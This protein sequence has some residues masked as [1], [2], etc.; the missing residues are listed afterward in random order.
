[1]HLLVILNLFFTCFHPPKVFPHPFVFVSHIRACVFIIFYHRGF[2]LS[3][4]GNTYT[5]LFLTC[6]DTCS[7]NSYI[8][9][10]Y[11]MHFPLSYFLLDSYDPY[12]LLFSSSHTF[13]ELPIFVRWG[14]DK[15]KCTSAVAKHFLNDEVC[16]SLGSTEPPLRSHLIPPTSVLCCLCALMCK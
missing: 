16:V 7:I 9:V 11:L 6:C 8:N 13:S 3:P 2:S 1:M 5:C 15:C 10:H 4:K 14:K 12:L